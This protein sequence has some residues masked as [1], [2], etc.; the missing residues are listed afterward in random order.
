MW[1]GSAEHDEI[2]TLP[3]IVVTPGPLGS[4]QWHGQCDR[5]EGRCAGGLESGDMMVVREEK[6][7]RRIAEVA[8]FKKDN[9]YCVCF[10]SHG[11]FPY[12]SWFIR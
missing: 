9:Q 6:G 3:A 10:L 5:A 7:L 8:Q 11:L 2:P 1:T 12:L 4:I